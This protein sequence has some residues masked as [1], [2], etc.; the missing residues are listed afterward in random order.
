MAAELGK[1]GVPDVGK[2]VNK[3]RRRWWIGGRVKGRR[4]PMNGCAERAVGQT[5]HLSLAV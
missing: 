1:A 4:F 2:A 3:I 5:V